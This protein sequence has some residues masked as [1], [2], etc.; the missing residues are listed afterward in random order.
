WREGQMEWRVRDV[1]R[2]GV[3]EVWDAGDEEEVDVVEV[4]EGCVEEWS[5]GVG[6]V[7]RGRGWVKESVVKR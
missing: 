3:G 1:E 2:V 4:G 7:E 5:R 6:E